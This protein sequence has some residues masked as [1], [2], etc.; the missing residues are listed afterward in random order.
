MEKSNT[1]LASGSRGRCQHDAA[2]VLQVH[3]QLRAEGRA[4]QV[5]IGSSSEGR[6]HF[7]GGMKNGSFHFPLTVIVNHLQSL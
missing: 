2:A 3:R 1:A 7:L 5:S 4:R 6:S